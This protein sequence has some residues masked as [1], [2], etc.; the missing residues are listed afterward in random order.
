MSKGKSNRSRPEK[1]MD[2]FVDILVEITKPDK[3]GNP[4]NPGAAMT[5]VIRQFLKDQNVSVD[6][7]KHEGMIRLKENVAANPMPFAE[8]PGDGD[9]RA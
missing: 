8:K 6:D 9:A 1:L 2:Q 7:D 3:D 4:P 5:N